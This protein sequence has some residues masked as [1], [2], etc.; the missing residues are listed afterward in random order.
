[1]RN[2]PAIT[3]RVEIEGL[4]LALFV[5]FAEAERGTRAPAVA[6]GRNWVGRDLKGCHEGVGGE[7]AGAGFLGGEEVVVGAG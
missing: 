6:L 1:V 7:E 3:G 2:E 5:G 4:L